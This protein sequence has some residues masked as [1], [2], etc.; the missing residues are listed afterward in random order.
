MLAQHLGDGQHQVGGRH[1]FLQ[2]AGQLEADHLG[3]QHRDRLAE[4]RRLRLDAADPPAEDG[5]A[6]HH[7][8]VAVGADQRVGIGDLD[9]RGV[10]VGPDRLP[11]VFQVHLVADAGARR[12][13]PE[14]GERAL[15]PLQ[16]LVA[17]AVALVLALDVELEG[18]R[19]AELVHHHRVVDDEIDRARAG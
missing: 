13:H 12:H 7:G 4:H 15:S 8:G 2:P 5:E 10:L 1:A 9:A 11:E 16:E 3:D 18:A 6:I 14:V 17:L 19:V